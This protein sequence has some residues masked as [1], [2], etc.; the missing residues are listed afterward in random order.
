MSSTYSP[1]P[2]P[3]DSLAHGLLLAAR[4]IADVGAGRSLSEAVGD[5]R[6][7]LPA[8]RAAAQDLAY[9]ALRRAGHGDFILGR[10]LQ[11]PLPDPLAHGLLL[12]ALYRLETRPEAPHTVVDQAVQA[13]TVI[14]G[15]RY[16]GLVN[17]VLRNALRQATQLA[18]AAAQDEV[19][20]WRHP[21]WWLSRLQRA[22]PQQWQA[23]ATA[24]NQQPPMTLRVNRRHWDL[25]TA[26]AAYAEAGIAVRPIGTCGLQ[27]S[28]ALPVDALPGFAEGWV[29]VQ[30][31]GA[32]EAALRLGAQDGERVLD[33]CAAPGGKSVHILELANVDLLALDVDE[34]RCQRINENLQRHRLQAE[35][36]AADCSNTAA[37][38]DGRPFDRILA[39]V[40][41]SASGVVRRH[42][43]AKWLRRND[44]IARFSRS[45]RQIVD[46]LWP[47]LRPGGTMLY[48]TCSVFPEENQQQ[49]DSFL[50]RHADAE[51]GERVQL[52][53]DDDH[54]GFFYAVLRKRS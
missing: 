33:A 23:V 25:A 32:Q 43:D 24:G 53:P 28:R 22:Y 51:A 21:H 9:G 1:A 8:A 7:E 2:P 12:A 37:W 41:C 49:V 16:K 35:V 19:A 13:A 10:L 18:Q 36:K 11:K 47:T 39:D 20:T 31:A 4:A 52:L 5:W 45:Q 46:A 38:W 48:A 29:A 14:A 40:P 54:D 26:A 6:Q 34:R 44:D 15:G 3:A 30:D 17:A 50:A 42:P 27:L